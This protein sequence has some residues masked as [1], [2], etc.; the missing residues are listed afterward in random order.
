M[1]VTIGVLVGS[2]G[3]FE[4]EVG[5][6][7]SVPLFETVLDFRLDVLQLQPVDVAEPAP[8]VGRRSREHYG[9]WY[10]FIV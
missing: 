8:R 9:T 1:A 4:L 10:R 7:D 5:L 6:R 3:A 2:I